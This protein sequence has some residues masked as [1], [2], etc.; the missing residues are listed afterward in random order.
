MRIFI[1]TA[2]NG[3]AFE[4]LP[5]SSNGNVGFLI[6]K[7]VEKTPCGKLGRWM[8]KVGAVW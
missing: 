1:N 3:C 6:L 7:E 5:F 8:G 2:N 4:Q